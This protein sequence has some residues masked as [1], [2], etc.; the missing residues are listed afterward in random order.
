VPITVSKENSRLQIGIVTFNAAGTVIT[1]T[2]ATTFAY[3]SP[4]ILRMDVLNGTTSACT[5]LAASPVLT[6]CALDATGTVTL[7]DNGS[8]LD[9]G[10]FKV[11]SEGH[12]EDQP[13]QLGAGSHALSASYSGDNSYNPSGPVPD[14]LTVTRATTT[15]ALAANQA[16]VTT[17]QTVT[18]TATIATQS[19]GVGPTGTVTFST[20]GTPPCTAT[21]VPTAFNPKT[22]AF[23][24]ATASL[25]TI[26]TTTGTKTITATYGGDTN[27]N[28]S[29]P[30]TAVSVTVTPSGSFTIGG[31]AVTV[32]AGASQLSTI[33]VTPSGG[34]ISTVN[35]TCLAAGL[36]PQGETPPT[37]TCSPNPLVINV[38]GA[39]AV[40][41]ALA[42]AVAAP[43]TTLTASA[44]PAAHTLYAAGVMPSNGSKGWWMLSAGTGL[45]AVFLLFLPGQKKYR[46]A[47]GLGLLCVLTFTMGC[48]SSSGGG[49]PVATTTTMT[50]NSAK[51]A[52]S[53]PTGFKFT[54]N[55][56]ASVGAN[57]QVQ[58]MDGNAAL[59]TAA[60][61][62]NGS[63]IITS[64]GLAPG[65][66]AIS[67]H[68][69]G[70]SK[71]MASNSGTLNVTST[72][73][74]TFVI[75]ANPAA[76]NAT[77]TVSV[78]IN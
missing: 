19:S 23:A 22:G 30:S 55:V 16:T 78:T 69:L 62:S 53:D 1:S 74:T 13:I 45:A 48:S 67:A 47:L 46:T 33:T 54:I 20:C 4:Y 56:A 9:G 8:P 73:T 44:A 75:S 40:N 61:V 18:L 57:G 32:T 65:T 77:P 21:L 6:G 27:Y 43:S 17:A 26:F 63:V 25:P 36:P 52:S 35:V 60:T 10:S 71:T 70:D 3:G 59:G 42:I 15:T 58:L 39:S 41:G 29:G 49:G 72:G 66:H 24:S 7:T 34:F 64:A 11:N 5:P 68:Y 76:S 14:A 28:G 51:L 2:N 50:V 37:T 12:T 31:S 38:T